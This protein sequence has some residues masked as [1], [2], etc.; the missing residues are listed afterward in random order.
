MI[1]KSKQNTKEQTNKVISLNQSEQQPEQTDE[2]QVLNPL[3]EKYCENEIDTAAG[4]FITCLIPLAEDSSGTQ[5][6]LKEVLSKYVTPKDAASLIKVVDVLSKIKPEDI[7]S[8]FV[9]TKMADDFI[10]D[11]KTNQASLLNVHTM[12]SS[13][14][15]RDSVY[16]LY[17]C[18]LFEI[19]YS[20]FITET[21]KAGQVIPMTYCLLPNEGKQ[22]YTYLI[23]PSRGYMLNAY[24]DEQ[25]NLQSTDEFALN[26][27]GYNQCLLLMAKSLAV[28]ILLKS[29]GVDYFQQLAPIHQFLEF[30]QK[31]VQ[32]TK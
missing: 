7:C 32:G 1:K 16:C 28:R 13:Q 26:Y 25:G 31:E 11:L 5:Y 24:A 18:K 30:Y 19:N 17:A 22:M 8:Q 23:E 12:L 14:E 3:Y 21:E 6:K 9:E 29:S 4:T 27:I 10:L 2:M 15:E 20:G